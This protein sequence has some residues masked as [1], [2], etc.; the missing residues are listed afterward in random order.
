MPYLTSQHSHSHF[1][2]K[3]IKMDIFDWP[4]FLIN[5]CIMVS[6]KSS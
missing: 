3:S 2:E 5:Q 6:E 4:H 1:D